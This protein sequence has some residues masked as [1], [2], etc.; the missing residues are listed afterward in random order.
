MTVAEATPLE[1][2]T[3]N[4]IAQ[5]FSWSGWTADSDDDIEVYVDGALRLIS[6]DYTLTL[7][8]TGGQVLFVA[9]PAS[10]AD[11]VVK[12]A[13]KLR[14]TTDYQFNGRL[15]ADTLDADFDRL[16]RAIQDAV[17]TLGRQI[18]LPINAGG[19]S[20]E[21]P[22]PEAGKLLGWNISETALRNY[23]P[24]GDGTTTLLGYE[25][26][27]ATA[28]QTV[29]DLAGMTYS[30]GT[31]N[32]I[33]T[34][35]GLAVTPADYAET[36]STR[37]TFTSGLSSGDEVVFRSFTLAEIVSV[38]QAGPYTA[39]ATGAV[40]RTIAS[41][42][43]DMLSVKDFGARGDGLTVD[44][45]AIAAAMAGA[46]GRPI[47]FPAGTY[48]VD[49]TLALPDGIHLVGDGRAVLKQR[50][51][52]PN[53]ASFYAMLAA[54]G[55][56]KSDIR[57]E[58][59]VFDGNRDA[60]VDHG[61]PNGAGNQ[62][63]AWTG[64][65]VALVAFQNVVRARIVNCEFRSSWGSGLWMTDCSDALVSGNVVRDCRIS[66]IAYRNDPGAATVGPDRTAIVGNRVSGCT[67]GIHCIFGVSGV[68]ISG[69][70]LSNNKD[71][72]RFP[73]V[74]YAGS[75][76]N[77][78]PITGGFNAATH[79]S[80]ASPALVGDGAGIEMT[81]GYTSPGSPP[82]Y[83]VIC[84][85][86][87]A[88]SNMVGVRAEELSANA[89]ISG[90]ACAFNEAHG[91]FG[92][93]SLRLAITGNMCASN[94]VSG[95][96]LE[97]FTGADR[98]EVCTVAGNLMSAN[99]LY[100]LSLVAAR[101]VAINGNTFG[102]NN[103]SANAIGGALGM[104]GLGGQFCENCAI[105]GNSF[106]NYAGDDEYGIYSSSNSHA[107]NVV[108]A[109]I[110]QS[111][112]TAALNLG[113]TSNR[114][115]GNVGYATSGYGGATILNGNTSVDVT[116]ALPFTPNA[117]QINVTPTANLATR[118]FWVSNIGASTFRINVSSAVGAD[119]TFSWSCVEEA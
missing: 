37:V 69:N 42:L 24:G 36:S 40:Q 81:G 99:G 105:V 35:N 13:T 46:A 62:P 27:I 31:N 64:T 39:Q 21:L 92:Y 20:P 8:D 78:Y 77:V 102:G 34:V 33:V 94:T 7:A 16:W 74:G 83:G 95:I 80:Y 19:V 86:N 45:D 72:N 100:G 68:T 5:L 115:S 114:I 70:V 1:R 29:F 71:A 11:V 79:P 60:N 44:D 84:A 89:V 101:H 10:G 97:R 88:F 28:S 111:F 23:D 26:Q 9:A 12:R 93:S 48:I 58:G 118:S 4:G 55:A 18:V 57:L 110:F 65:L 103:T 117:G 22:M 47:F 67:I 41:K 63:A 2:Y 112:G 108:T 51:S 82:N 61:S 85:N 56:A 98:T 6:S 87:V 104:D 25:R 53:R 30:P 15:Y 54:E 76:P 91:I 50:A 59:L 90:N 73:A 3:G 66:G 109:N 106:S 96:R 107:Q 32:L 43:G 17:A 14:R 113:F 75:Y 116:H 119:T 38:A 49:S 52:N